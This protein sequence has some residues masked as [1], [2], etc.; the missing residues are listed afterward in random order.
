VQLGSL[1]GCALSV[2]TGI[3][4]S[5][6]VVGYCVG[7]GIKAFRWA[8]GVMQDLG[9][10]PDFPYGAQAYAVNYRGDVAG[11]IFQ[12]AVVQRAALYKNGRWNDLGSLYAG[13]NTFAYGMND[14]AH[15]VGMDGLYQQPIFWSEQTGLRAL[16]N[17]VSN[18]GSWTAMTCQAINNK[19]WIV[20]T[21]LVR[22]ATDQQRFSA[23][24]MIPTEIEVEPDSLRVVRGKTLSGDLD[25]LQDIDGDVLRLARYVV[26]N[27]NVAPVSF[28][29]EATLPAEA[30]NLWVQSYGQMVTQ[31]SFEQSLSLY[32]WTVGSFDSDDEGRK[33][34]G[35]A[36]L[37]LES[38]ARGNLARY[39][40]SDRKV[41]ARVEVR[42]S[43]PSARPVWE[44]EHDFV[45][46][47]MVPRD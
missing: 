40:R 10:H 3:N 36:P 8:E 9:K 24:V 38:L 20:G 33:P 39:V 27:Q 46:F 29:V 35:R 25:S 15:V 21:G 23:F 41:R 13:F 14:L 16:R 12:S 32:D 6:V 42:S 43:G 22:Y 44:C 7:S 18:W 26:P 17:Y 5:D 19:G 34:F 37:R 4:D 31:G 47:R 45:G 11:V 1:P 2:A 28:E 30:M